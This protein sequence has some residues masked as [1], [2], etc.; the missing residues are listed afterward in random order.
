MQYFVNEFDSDRWINPSRI[1]SYVQEPQ[2]TICR[3]VYSAERPTDADCRSSYPR[4]RPDPSKHHISI[5]NFPSLVKVTLVYGH[6]IPSF[7]Q[8]PMDF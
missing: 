7:K 5:D 2:T 8:N 6:R 1:S 4:V 3:P